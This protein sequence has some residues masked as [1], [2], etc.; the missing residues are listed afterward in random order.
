MTSIPF[1]VQAS[2]NCESLEKLTISDTIDAKSIDQ[3]FIEKILDPKYVNGQIYPYDLNF[4]SSTNCYNEHQQ[5]SWTI[6]ED[7]STRDQDKFNRL[8]NNFK[9]VVLRAIGCILIGD[10]VVLDSLSDALTRITAPQVRAMLT[11]QMSRETVHK[12]VYSMMLDVCPLE[13]E[14]YRSSAFKTH[15]MSRFE[16]L[17]IKY[18]DNSIST[19]LYFIMLCENI[20]FAPMFQI[21]CYL[22]TTGHA[23]SIC[24]QN[25]L[26][27]RDEYVHY[28]H[29]RGL[30]SELK[31]KIDKALAR[32]ILK[33]F[34]DISITLIRDIIKEFDNGEF[35][36]KHVLKHFNYVV[37][38]FMEKN[39]LYWDTNEF[40]IGEAEHGQTPADYYLAAPSY[41]IKSN[42]ME[43]KNT[44]YTP[45]SGPTHIDI[46]NLK[47]QFE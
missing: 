43:S 27:M 35:N 10:S 22:A 1:S 38:K 26:V 2:I 45:S 4:M 23:P 31:Y 42:L 14:Y 20:L 28:K 18:N 32:D 8:D 6:H 47:K 17:G 11:D 13:A 29:A 5:C 44:V 39:T 33:E 25:V 15:Y 36:A 21:L 37:H 30:L 9:H 12:V 16:K 40:D 46:R 34:T 41:E 3:N 7:D 24:S 19:T